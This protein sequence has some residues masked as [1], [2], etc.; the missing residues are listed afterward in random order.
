VNA[1]KEDVDEPLKHITVLEEAHNLL[2]RTSMEQSQESSNLQGK[3]VEMLANAIAEMRSYG[4]GF[5]IVDQS[6]GL[7]DMSVIRNTNTKIILRL[8]DEND[9]QLVGKAAGLNEA[10]IQELTKLKVGVAAISQNN[11][12]EPVLCEVDHYTDKNPYDLNKVNGKSDFITRF[13]QIAINPYEAYDLEEADKSAIETWQERLNISSKARESIMLILEGR[14][15]VLDN[16]DYNIMLS[17]ILDAPHLVSTLE[18]LNESDNLLDELEIRLAEKFNLEPDTDK[19]LIQLLHHK[20]LE[21]YLFGLDQDSSGDNF[22]W[23]QLVERVRQ[24]EGRVI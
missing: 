11:W 7:L 10:Q 6:P 18:E 13:L 19:E 14:G 16:L 1:S 24:A 5:I 21:V 22:R 3:S 2:R 17:E 4:E 12:V 8:P 20:T 15:K 23:R 9:R